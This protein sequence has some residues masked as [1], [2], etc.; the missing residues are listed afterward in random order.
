[1]AEINVTLSITDPALVAGVEF[2]RDLHNEQNKDQ[3]P[4][5]SEEYVL[6]VASSAAMSYALQAT[7]TAKLASVGVM[8]MP[9][10]YEDRVKE[11]Q[12]K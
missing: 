7:E 2:A 5:S 11:F 12:S 3:K 6:F 4:L 1:M 8:K 9:Q 10:N